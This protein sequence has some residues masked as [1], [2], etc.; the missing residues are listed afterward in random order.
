M[1]LHPG[2]RKSTILDPWYFRG[3]YD[4]LGQASCLRV[5][6]EDPL[7]QG[8]RNALWSVGGPFPKSVLETQ[9]PRHISEAFKDLRVA[10]RHRVSLPTDDNET[11]VANWLEGVSELK[12]VL[13]EFDAIDSKEPFD[14]MSGLGE[15]DPIPLDFERVRIGQASRFD[16]DEP[17][18]LDYE[19]FTRRNPQAASRNQEP[20]F[21]TGV[22]DQN[23]LDRDDP[24]LRDPRS[25]LQR[26]M[27]PPKREIRVVHPDTLPR[28][29]F[30][31]ATS[32]ARDIVPG[33]ELEKLISSIQKLLRPMPV[34]YGRVELRAEMGRFFAS[35]VPASGLSTNSPGTPANGWEA[36][37]L[38]EKLSGQAAFFTQALSCF[39]NDVDLLVKM[40]NQG[41]EMAIWKP[42]SRNVFL[43]FRFRVP[44]G[45]V[46]SE[47]VENC[48]DLVLEVNT[49]DYSWSIRGW[50]NECGSACVHCLRQHWDFRVRL[51]HDRSLEYEEYWGAFAKAL[52]D[53][54]EVSP[55]KL[56]FQYLFDA[57]PVVCNK[58]LPILVTD[59]RVRQVCRFRHHH[60]K[61]YLDITRMSPTRPTKAG[62][63]ISHCTEVATLT[64]AEAGEFTHWYQAAISS[65]RLENILRENATLIPGDEASWKAEHLAQEVRDLCEQATSVIQQ[66]DPVGVSC[67]NGFDEKYWKPIVKKH[68]RNYKF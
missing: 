33:E 62:S 20:P 25:A 67:D 17:V 7:R 45:T 47:G 52:I 30:S 27:L 32:Q 35:K 37:R 18:T 21:R 51:S 65:V 14:P 48:W 9:K 46:T 49:K 63:R 42:Y 12:S 43:D 34:R 26:P 61:T 1:N 31:S 41:T 57:H 6:L 19:Q 5:C 50:D 11:D 28:I 15:D 8:P 29:N 40:K 4:C 56:E 60:G 13:P 39:G 3:R 68:T 2:I 16:D 53:S 55:P 59:V 10:K 24:I 66:M 44:H 22:K 58:D 54:L 38:R 23:I 36:E 64:K